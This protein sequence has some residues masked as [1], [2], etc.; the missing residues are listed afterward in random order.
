MRAP[1]TPTAT[2][3]SAYDWR[4]TTNAV[5]G[6]REQHDLDA[7]SL[8]VADAR[9]RRIARGAE[10][11]DEW[12]RQRCG[13]LDRG[14]AAAPGAADAI[15]YDSRA[16]PLC[17][18]GSWCP[19]R[20]SSPTRRRSRRRRRRSS[21][22]TAGTAGRRRRAARAALRA[23]PRLST[24]RRPPA[25]PS[26]E[27]RV[28]A[29]RIRERRLA[30]DAAGQLVGHRR[31]PEREREHDEDALLLRRRGLEEPV[32]HVEPPHAAN[33]PERRLDPFATCADEPDRHA[34]LDRV[35]HRVRRRR[36]PPATSR[37]MT[38]RRARAARR[39]RDRRV[40][41]R[42]PRG[43][44]ERA[45]VAVVHDL[46]EAE[47]ARGVDEL[48]S[49]LPVDD[50]R[51]AAAR[52]VDLEAVV[53]VLERACSP[54]PA[55]RRRRRDRS[56]GS[57]AT[58]R[59]RRRRRAAGR[60]AGCGSARAVRLRAGRAAASRHRR[61]RAARRLGQ[62]NRP[63]SVRAK[64]L[65]F[66][67]STETLSLRHGTRPRL[68]RRARLRASAASAASAAF[69]C[70]CTARLAP[71]L[72]LAA[73]M[74][75]APGVLVEE[76][77]PLVHAVG[78]YGAV[79]PARTAPASGRPHGG[80]CAAVEADLARGR[81]EPVGPPVGPVAGERLQLAA[82]RE[83]LEELAVRRRAQLREGV[84]AR[85]SARA[86][87]AGTGLGAALSAIV[88][89]T[90]RCRTSSGYGARASAGTPSARR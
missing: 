32:R 37:D 84:L 27:S 64:P 67:T 11:G 51:R 1:A 13:R 87:R 66:S 63:T 81:S 47:R 34:L 79:E 80:L 56:A 69:V 4:W 8:D 26:D 7:G 35:R 9:R 3:S 86:I 60:A 62:E 36:R 90:R 42:Q 12:L 82:L 38:E 2:G 14:P 65:G 58:E 24:C 21:P 22:G 53:L 31:R 18:A 68:R 85:S 74:R 39:S 30:A 25:R 75:R 15:A 52:D 49:E 61:P 55:P 77:D 70:H 89:C 76:R 10:H 19:R 45:A 28:R 71:G 43:R 33:E 23:W 57:R 29:P 54:P 20:C 17:E 40:A 48:D 88:P 16:S 72:R 50:A 41:R 59:P 5:L 78:F 44:V 83:R 73:R 46:A 6:R